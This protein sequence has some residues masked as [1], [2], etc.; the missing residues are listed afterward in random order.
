MTYREPAER[1]G[2]AKPAS[3]AE[4]VFAPKAA[5]ADGEKAWMS[6]TTYGLAGGFSSAALLSVL[7]SP[8]AGL[9]GLVGAF[10][11]GVYL[12]K[13]SGKKRVLVVTKGVLEVKDAPTKPAVFATPLADLLDVRL[14]TKEVRRLQEGT[15]TVTGVRYEDNRSVTTTEHGRLLLVARRADGTKAPPFPLLTEYVAHMEASEWLGKVRVFL[16]KQGWVP[17]DERDD[18]PPESDVPESDVPE[19]DVPASEG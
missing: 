15:N 14:D 13:R 11:L 4:L 16:R 17:A 10:A 5:Q 3:H 7:V 19:S 1:D 12:A 9:A 8:T 2:E 6:A 18:L